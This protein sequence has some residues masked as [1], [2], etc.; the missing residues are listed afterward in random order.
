MLC[1]LIYITLPF[2]QL[3]YFISSEKKLT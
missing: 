1:F 2:I 3:V